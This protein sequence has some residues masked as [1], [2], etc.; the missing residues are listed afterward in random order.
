MKFAVIQVEQDC[1]YVAGATC[2]SLFLNREQAED[3]IQK[4]KERSRNFYNKRDEYFLDFINKIDIPEECVYDE[5]Q[6]FLKKYRLGN[7]YT[8]RD[9]FKKQLLRILQLGYTFEGFQIPE[10]DYVDVNNLFVDEIKED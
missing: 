6:E 5:F 10:L 7:T 8:T 1:D 2:L 9:N 4:L 3:Y